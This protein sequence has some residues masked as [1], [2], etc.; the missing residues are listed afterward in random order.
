MAPEKRS[1]Q[2]TDHRTRVGKERSARTEMRIVEAALGVFAEMGP[3]AP[4]IDDFLAA[5]GISRGTFYNHFESVEELL[6][7]TSQWTT[8]EMIETVDHALEGIEDPVLRLGIGL[9]LFL[10]RA[11]NDRP[12]CG[13]VAR[14][15]RPG[16]LERP[17]RDL[18]DGLRRGVFRAPTAE[19]AQD[20]LFGALRQAL[21]RISRGRT[22]PSYSSHVTELC[23]Q[24]LAADP[25][26]IRAVIKHD[27]PALQVRVKSS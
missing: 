10:E 21:L 7:A 4:K 14:V 27:L 13:F 15:W 2:K 19:V 5:A 8:R 17:A 12:W 6:T 22:P 3:D 11:R 24:A 26:Q 9:R 25:R 18:A 20:V 23:L 1:R 16:G